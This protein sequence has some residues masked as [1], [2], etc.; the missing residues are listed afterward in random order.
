VR[1]VL[2]EAVTGQAPVPGMV[3]A[4]RCRN[5]LCVA[6]GCLRLMTVAQLRK[7]DA[8][9][10]AFSTAQANAARLLSARRRAVIPEEL[11]ALVR[12]HEGTCAQAAAATGV[13]LSHSKNIRAGRAR[14]PL[15]S[16]WSGLVR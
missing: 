7:I 14:K 11:V 9:R 2:Y 4:P 8:A 15:S 13:S 16:P 12:G 3:V 10:G 6:P 1:R 5:T